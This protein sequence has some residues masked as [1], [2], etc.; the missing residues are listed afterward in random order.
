MN[1]IFKSPQIFQTVF[2][3]IVLNIGILFFGLNLD[4]TKFA[5]IFLSTTLLD[6]LFGWLQF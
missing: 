3:M 5:V 6:M 2:L 1:L 4:Y